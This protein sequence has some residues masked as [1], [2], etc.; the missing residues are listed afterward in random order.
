MATKKKTTKKLTKKPA[1][2]PVTR[3]EFNK[4]VERVKDVNA[5]AHVANIV[6]QTHEKL[7]CHLDARLEGLVAAHNDL[8]AGYND[9]SKQVDFP[10]Q[11]RT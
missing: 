7:I 3:A 11:I 8:V 5:F 1:G 2:K 6:N 10:T 9:L 4:L